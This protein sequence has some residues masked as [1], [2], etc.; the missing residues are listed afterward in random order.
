MRVISGKY[1]GRNLKGFDINGTRPTMDRVKES[2]FSMIN[3]DIKDSIILDLFSGSGSL[4][5][6]GLSNGAKSAYLVDNNVIAINTINENINNLSIDNIYVIKNDALRQLNMFI[7]EKKVFDI[8][9]LDPPYNTN[10]LEDVLKIINANLNI[11][12]D[13]GIIVCETTKSIDY[14]AYD[15]LSIH[16]EKKYGDK[17][18]IILKKI[19]T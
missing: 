5:I 10:Y 17:K 11:L 16:K 14:S 18:V 9:F 12:S 4:A 7:N 6:E 19:F 15:K 13:N 2:V 1:K 8:I 3:L